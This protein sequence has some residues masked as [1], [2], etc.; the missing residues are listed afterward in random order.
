MVLSGSD[1]AS[2]FFFPGDC[3]V[4]LLRQILM[5]LIACMTCAG[6]SPA[7]F[8]KTEPPQIQSGVLDLQTW[9]FAAGHIDLAGDWQVVWQE[10]SDPTTFFGGSERR[11][12]SV[13]DDWAASASGDRPFD[14]TGYATYG[15]RI[16]LPGVHPELALDLG[17]QRYAST[18]FIDT[19]LRRRSGTPAATR[20]EEEA[21]AWTRM[22]VIR[23]PASNGQPHSI[24]IVVHNSNFV[25]A[26]GGFRSPMRIGEAGAVVRSLALETVVRLSLV[27]G[28]LLLALYHLILFLNRRQEKEFLLFTAF[29][30]SITVHELCNLAALRAIVPDLN[31]SVMLHLEYLSLV[32]GAWFG[33]S[34]IWH[35]YPQ[36]RWRLLGRILLG[37]ALVEAVFIVSVPPLIFTSWLPVLQL[38]VLACTVTGTLSLCVAVARKLDGARLFLLSQSIAAGGA[39]YGIVMIALYGYSVD[40]VVYLCVSAM[41]LG[42]AAVLGRRITSAITTSETLRS[43]LQETNESLEETVAS[44]TTSL[45]KAVEDSRK[46]LMAS[47]SANQVKSK[48]LAMMSH[49]IR[50]PMNG[51]IGV[52]SLLQDSDLDKKQRKLLN[53][54]KQ[55]GD[56]LLMILNDI[57]DISKVEAGELV[58]E[59]RDFELEPLFRRCFALWQPRAIEKELKLR[60]DLNV[61]PGLFLLGD[62]HRLMQIIS[63]LV[64]N[65]IKFT[66]AGEV[67]IS[68]DIRDDGP[69]R[70]QLILQ[71]RD[72]GIGIP[73]EAREAIF[74]PFQQADLSTTRKYGGTGLGLSICSQLIDMMNGS[75]TISDNETSATGT[76]FEVTLVLPVGKSGGAVKEL[77]GG[78]LLRSRAS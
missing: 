13:P 31:A 57:L 6:V 73:E 28:T 20:S 55:S 24:E 15:L 18:V 1:I 50:T 71:V 11:S 34:F 66:T 29:L 32:L 12:V 60:L 69:D 40:W 49:E 44:R 62:E 5:V 21:T 51:I 33:V 22:G 2:W 14:R 41:L 58:L 10:L 26:R 17:A 78:A 76:N 63:N 8:A 37:V 68:G 74:Q 56:D 47:H 23:I 7:A 38:S 42:Q 64:S 46:A 77:S 3:R 48:F 19:K 16:V 59:E 36:T 70:V 4:Y 39:S 27:G 43:R 67:C 9:D 53:V 65:G 61:P 54:I 72:T 35:L 75:V 25:H 45:E 30:L 52:A